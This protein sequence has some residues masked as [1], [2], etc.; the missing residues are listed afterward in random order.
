MWVFLGIPRTAYISPDIIMAHKENYNRC[1][2]LSKKGIHFELNRK[3]KWTD[4]HTVLGN[5]CCNYRSGAALHSGIQCRLSVLHPPRYSHPPP[6]LDGTFVLALLNSSEEEREKKQ[7]RTEIWVYR[8][9]KS[10]FL[11]TAPFSSS[12][13]IIINVCLMV[14]QLQSSLYP[15]LA[16][17]FL[18]THLS[19]SPWP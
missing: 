11:L 16:L 14:N 8:S 6:R 10:H 18:F 9:K 1:T 7:W 12:H 2:L 4:L 5:V 17:S 19:S 15:P 13:P 3:C